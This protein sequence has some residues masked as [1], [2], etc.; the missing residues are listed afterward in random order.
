MA[1][2]RI[3]KFYPNSDNWQ[4]GDVVEIS[5]PNQLILEGKVEIFTPVVVEEKIVVPVEVEEKPKKKA[6][7]NA[8][9]TKKK[10]VK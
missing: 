6:F 2:C 7:K 5:S 3:L 9:K 4:E 8:P 10:G 1:L